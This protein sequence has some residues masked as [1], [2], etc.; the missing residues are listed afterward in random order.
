MS[1]E[2]VVLVRLKVKLGMEEKFR[3]SLIARRAR[4][5]PGV[6]E[7]VVYEDVAD[8]MSCFA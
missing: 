2:L 5:E 8:S 7:I 6:K 3:D 1:E 4:T